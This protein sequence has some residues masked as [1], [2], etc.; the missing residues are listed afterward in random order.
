M[1]H[2]EVREGIGTLCTDK[3]RAG[4]ESRSERRSWLVKEPSDATAAEAT[5]VPAE[6]VRLAT[7]EPNLHGVTG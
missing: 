3:V 4:G 1:G 5:A 7:V 6:T 2:A